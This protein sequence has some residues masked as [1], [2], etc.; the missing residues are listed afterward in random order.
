MDNI[1]LVLC[2]ID[3]TLLTSQLTISIKTKEAIAKLHNQNILFG[4]ATG[5]T[6]YAVKNLIVDWGIESYVDFIMGFNGGNYLDLHT[7]TMTSCYLLDGEYIPVILE[8][9]K[10]FD[11]NVGLYDQKSF[12]CLKE[13]HHARQI[14]NNNKLPLVIDD[15]TRYHHKKINK[16][17]FMAEPHVID[18]M[19]NYAC[20]V[21]NKGYRAVRSTPTLLE[22]LNPE[23]S[24]AKGIDLICHDLG[25]RFENVLAFGDELNDLEMIRDCVGVCMGNGHQK[26]K[27]VAQ[28]ITKSNDEDGIGLFLNEHILNK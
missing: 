12:H 18:E 25:I 1:K 27:E 2:D 15:L 28:F 13:D 8:N 24:K 14:S 22:F 19:A 21:Q 7:N 4:I 9:F 10:H 20:F 26:V 23:L 11:K 6:P 16:L 5:R 3:G 17:L